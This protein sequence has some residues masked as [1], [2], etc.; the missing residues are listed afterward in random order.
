MADLCCVNI[1]EEHIV[2]KIKLNKGEKKKIQDMGINIGNKVSIISQNDS[3]V[4]I[5]SGSVRIAL[6]KSIALNIEV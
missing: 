4:I 3:G 1:G 2:K 6:D 5:Q